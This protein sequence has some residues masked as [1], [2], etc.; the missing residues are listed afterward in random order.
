M[1][2]R[3]L[4]LFLLKKSYGAGVFCSR[5]SARTLMGVTPI[6]SHRAPTSRVIIGKETVDVGGIQVELSIC[7][8]AFSCRDSL[9][10]NVATFL[11]TLDPL[12]YE[13]GCEINCSI[14]GESFTVK[15]GFDCW[16]SASS[17]ALQTSALD[18]A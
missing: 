17:K 12:K 16:K 18:W 4:V 15:E 11:A 6:P 9:D 3:I 8:P 10:S 5:P 7:R 1:L 2:D 14:N 13:D